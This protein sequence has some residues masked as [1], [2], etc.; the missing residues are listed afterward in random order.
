VSDPALDGLI[1]T[2]GST[3]PQADAATTTMPASLI[4]LRSVTKTY[5]AGELAVTA[6]GGARPPDREG[7]A[8]GGH[9]TLRI[10]QVDAHAH[11]GCLDTPTSEPITSKARTS[12]RC[13]AFAWRRYA[14]ARW[15]SSSRPLNLL[16]TRLG[17]PQRRAA[18]GLRRDRRRRKTDAGDRGPQACRTRGTASSTDP[19]S[20]R[21][22]AAARRHRPRLVNNPSLILADEPTGNLDTKTGAEIIDILLDL[23]SRGETIVIVTHDQRIASRCQRVVQ[24]VDGRIVDDRLNT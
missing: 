4:D 19:A 20:S 1:L 11:H 14:I 24:I 16:P 5:D 17:S 9:R 22:T 15:D 21:W 8:R 6:L 2:L 7:S 13:R 3:I 10:G 23:H 18:S 12:R